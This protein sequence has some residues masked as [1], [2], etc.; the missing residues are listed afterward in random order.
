MNRLNIRII[1]L[2]LTAILCVTRALAHDFCVNGIYYDKNATEAAV[3]FRGS[4]YSYY[5]NEYSGDVVIPSTVTYN[6]TTYIVTS[7]GGNAFRDCSKLTSITIPNSVTSIGDYAFYNID[8]NLKLTSV[9]IPNSV[10]YIG[11]FAFYNRW[12]LTSI[13]IPNSVTYIGNSAFYNCSGLTSITIPNSV[14]YI[15]NEAF[16]NCGLNN[17]SVDSGNDAYDSRENCNAIIH[18]ASNSLVVGCNNTIIPNI[19]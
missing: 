11:N 15:G 2:L 12:G 10:T 8:R 9:D 16:C 3:T 17:I 4:T 7:I 6:G 18:T 1:L 14:T 13:D 5:D 19:A